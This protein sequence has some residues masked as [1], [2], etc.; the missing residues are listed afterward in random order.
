VRPNCWPLPENRLIFY[1]YHASLVRR[2]SVFLVHPVCLCRLYNIDQSN[3]PVSRRLPAINPHG[4]KANPT[5]AQTVS[6][7][8]FAFEG[9][10]KFFG[11]TVC[12]ITS[13]STKNKKQRMVIG[14]YK[15]IRELIRS[16]SSTVT[17]TIEKL[18]HPILLILR[19]LQEEARLTYGRVVIS[20]PIGD[21]ATASY[22]KAKATSLSSTLP[23]CRYC[24]FAE[25]LLDF[26][27]IS[28]SHHV[29]VYR[30]GVRLLE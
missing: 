13:R 16:N 22:T 25:C 20:S 24:A 6:Q 14:Y 8:V 5:S 21:L 7:C 29:A 18:P 23:S 1:M 3:G 4:S 10:W 19:P 12:T 15:V 2:A 28:M 17:G 9:S 26:S 27:V 11:N 30:I